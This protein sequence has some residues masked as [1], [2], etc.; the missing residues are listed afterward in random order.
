M[1]LENSQKHFLTKNL[2]TDRLSIIPFYVENDD[3][4][5]FDFIDQTLTSTVQLIMINIFHSLVSD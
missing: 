2:N 5:R 3:D 4:Q 1:K